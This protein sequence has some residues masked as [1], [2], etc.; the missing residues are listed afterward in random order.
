MKWNWGTGIFLVIVAFLAVCVAFII[1]SQ[2]QKWSM[3]EE[4]YYPKELRHEEKLVK[5]RNAD[6]LTTQLQVKLD[7]LNLVL[8]FPDDF[9]GKTITGN[10]DIYRP[11]DEKLD[12]ILPVA[13]DTS[14]TQLVSLK[15][16]TQGRYVVKVDWTSGGKD[17]Y[18]EQDIFI[19]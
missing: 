11:S 3:V 19:P 7:P 5:M 8:Q 1:Y 6:A 10:I 16:L 14:L 4:D 12:V 2:H 17:Y 15:K 9:R 18:K 13:P